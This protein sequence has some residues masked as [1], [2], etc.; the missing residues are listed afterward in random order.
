M[1]FNF[2]NQR[3]RDLCKCQAAYVVRHV[4]GL[5]GKAEKIAADIGN[6]F[7]AALIPHFQGATKRKV[8]AAFEEE[9]NKVIPPG[10]QPEEDRF[11]RNNCLKIMERY[12][13]VR[14]LDKFPFEAVEFETV[15]GIPIDESGELIFWVKRDLLGKLKASGQLVPVDHKT[16]GRI[17]DWWSHKF[18]L[19]SQ[20]TGYTWFTQQESGQASTLCLVNAIEVAKL[21]SSSNRCP[22]HGVKYIECSSEHCNFKMLQ[23]VR[24]PEQIAKWR[25]DAITL[26]RQAEMLEQVYADISMIPF[27]LKTG[28][29]SEDCQF[30][31]FKDPCALGFT[32]EALA[33][34]TVYERW[35]PWTLK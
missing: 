31:E 32:P 26:A 25:A 11:E 20:M 19:S 22:K 9:Y 29:F 14:P 28:C 2:D 10:Q 15:K 27:A 16:T 7:H 35:E 3:L 6:V 5:V 34:F 4:H 21:P 24:S 12:C 18:K 33:E 23:Y 13:D 8:S 30:C 1:P 17:T